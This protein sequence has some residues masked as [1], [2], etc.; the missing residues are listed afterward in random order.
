MLS[1]RLV[2]ATALTALAIGLGPFAAAAE[3]YPDRPI[4]LIVPYPAGGGTDAIARVIAQGLTEQLGQQLVVDNNGT[5]GGN[6]ATAQAAKADPDGSTIERP[7]SWP[8]AYG[9]APWIIEVWVNFISNAVKYAGTKPRITLGAERSGDGLSARFWV[10]D[11]GP[12]INEEAQRA[13]FVPFTRI[14][15]VRAVG[16]GLGLSIV[17]RIVEKLGGK[18]G[19]DSTLGKGAKFWFELPT[20]VRPHSASPFVPAIAQ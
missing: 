16:H 3:S 6:V 1:K 17:R 18:V 7:N 12:G 2:L 9:H 8:E 14:T 20:T 10:Q 13:M 15:T 19:V 4:R 11:Y 5:A